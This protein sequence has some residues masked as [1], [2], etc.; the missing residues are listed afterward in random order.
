MTVTRL[1]PA[2]KTATGQPR[3]IL[4]PNALTV[5]ITMEMKKKRIDLPKMELNTPAR[6]EADSL[7]ARIAQP[8]GVHLPHIAHA[9]NTDAL[10]ILHAVGGA[11]SLSCKSSGHGGR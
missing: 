5:I 4:E 7:P 2:T 10:P 11:Q 8:A 9:D 6:D 1:L 3:T